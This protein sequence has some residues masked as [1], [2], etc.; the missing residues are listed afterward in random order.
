MYFSAGLL[1]VYLNI[2]NLGLTGSFWVYILPYLVTVFGLILIRTFIEN[3]PKSLEESAALDGANDMQI[4]FRI[5]FPLC[6]PVIAA[7]TLFEFV[8]HW[9]NFTDTLLYNMHTPRL[10]TLQY[11]LSNYL[12]SMFTFSAHDF[13]DR[14]A[15][16]E[17][18]FQ[19][20]RMA[21]SVVICLPIMIVY[22]FLQRFFIKGI[23]VG[24]IKG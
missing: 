2:A 19:T 11:V 4:A 20:V 24:S 6:L 5:I 8:N 15:L 18:N 7:I 21:M 14:A 12:V 17:F 23:L 3:L 10:F 1:P 13:A 9:N 16:M 22:P